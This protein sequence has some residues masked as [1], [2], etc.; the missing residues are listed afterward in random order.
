MEKNRQNLSCRESQM[1]YIDDKTSRRWNV[2][3][4]SSSVGWASD[5]LP[6]SMEKKQKS[7]FTVEKPDKPQTGNQS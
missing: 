7:N 4:H 1:T 6:K 3:P 2:I 5:C